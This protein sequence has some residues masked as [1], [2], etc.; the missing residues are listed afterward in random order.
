[1]LSNL[2]NRKYVRFLVQAIILFFTVVVLLKILHS[3][4]LPCDDRLVS[5]EF[6]EENSIPARIKIDNKGQGI[7]SFVASFEPVD[8]LRIWNMK[9]QTPK[10]IEGVSVP[11]VEVEIHNAHLCADKNVE[12]IIFVLTKPQNLGRRNLMRRTWANPRLFERN[13]TRVIFV[14][15]QAVDINMKDR[16]NEEFAKHKDLVIGNFPDVA[17]M[18]SLKSILA[19]KWISENCKHAHFAFK[20]N[21]DV[22][23]NIFGMMKL[24]KQLLPGKRSI[25]CPLW[26]PNT[27]RILRKDCGEFCVSAKD[28]PDQQY[29]P[30]YCAGVGFITPVNL[31]QELYIASI[32]TP[33]FFIEDVYTTGILP[34]KLVNP[35]TFISCMRQY[36]TDLNATLSQYFNASFPIKTF[37]THL[38]DSTAYLKLWK[39]L[40]T[41]LNVQG[42]RQL[43]ESL[44]LN[45]TPPSV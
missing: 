28:F 1:M 17:R 14:M 5:E 8:L 30:Q 3:W 40:L 37:I 13:I 19:M 31:L 27:M 15:G 18:Q 41:R 23:V 11:L 9:R 12:W 4:T 16:T 39:A 6:N 45:N 36:S 32:K 7:V 10:P 34:T 21:D 33:V 24:A 2:L 38:Y 42:D 20:V 44:I 26:L 43:P 25:L 22:F 35:P 29:F